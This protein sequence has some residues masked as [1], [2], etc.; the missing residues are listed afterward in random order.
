MNPDRDRILEQ[1]LTHELGRKTP[2]GDVCLD[3]ETLAAWTDG[4]LDPAAV[5]AIEAHASSCARCQELIAV[6]ARTLPAPSSAAIPAGSSRSSWW[7]WLVPVS[8]AAAAAVIWMVVPGQRQ[9]SVAPPE[10]PAAAQA[11]APQ[12]ADDAKPASPSAVAEPRANSVAAAEAPRDLAKQ[13]QGVAKERDQKL[14]DAAP[15]DRTQTL[16]ASTLKAEQQAAANVQAAPAAPAAAAPA[17]AAPEKRLEAFAT[18]SL[19]QAA[20]RAVAAGV[21]VSSPDGR[22][23]WRVAVDSIERT[24]DGGTSWAM[25]HLLRGET[26]AAGSSPSTTVCWFVGPGGTVMITVDASVFTHVDVPGRLDLRSIVAA[27]ARSAVVTTADGRRFRTDDSG[28]N[29]REN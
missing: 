26:L 1:A 4:G 14:A 27:D 23:R 11:P 25:V 5:A 21:E 8:A 10:R 22:R 16:S 24:D 20:R 2:P 17:A 7:K 6:M 18:A 15:T 3:A 13:A 19:D 9:L 29:W 28:R 12:R